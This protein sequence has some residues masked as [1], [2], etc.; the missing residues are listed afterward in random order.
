M[1]RDAY[2][3]KGPQEPLYGVRKLGGRG[4]EGQNGACQYKGY[5]AYGNKQ[6]VEQA[7]L[8][9]LYKAPL[10]QRVACAVEDI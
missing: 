6:A 10:P 1:H 9:Y 3:G 7:V 8:G 4:G 2:S 5:D